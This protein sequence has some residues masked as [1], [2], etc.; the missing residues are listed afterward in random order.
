LE[1]VA[2]ISEKAERIPKLQGRVDS[3][4][5]KLLEAHKAITYLRGELE[6]LLG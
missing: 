5:K 6:S 3:A 4:A 2:I 1:K